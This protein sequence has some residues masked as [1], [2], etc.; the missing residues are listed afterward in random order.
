MTTDARIPLRIIACGALA[1][2]L[3]ATIA[4]NRLSHVS[5][6]CLPASLHNRPE[7]IPDAVRQ[8]IDEAQTEG[9]RV[10]VAYADCGTG[11]R[12]DAVLAHYGVARLPGPHCYAVYSGVEAFLA[13]GDTDMRTFFLT[14]FLV[15]QFDTLVIEGLGLDRHPQLRDSYFGQYTTVAYLAQT[16]DPALEAAARV[17]A[18]RLGLNFERRNVGFGDLSRAVLRAATDTRPRRHSGF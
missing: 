1:R 9:A 3:L 13:G 4:A 6:T 10:F 18:A 14:D 15:R 12:L 17:A 16:H 11:G 8:A 2:E 7:R 5:V